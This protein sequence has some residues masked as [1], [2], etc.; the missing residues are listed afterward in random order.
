MSR[1]REGYA[2]N[3]GD[4]RVLRTLGAELVD[5]DDATIEAKA[6]EV[7]GDARRLKAFVLDARRRRGA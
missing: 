2:A 1:K 4:D 3:W 6:A 7:G 5:A